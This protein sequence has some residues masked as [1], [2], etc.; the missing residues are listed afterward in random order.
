MGTSPLTVTVS[1]LSPEPEHPANA[2]ASSAAM[3][4]STGAD[5][6][7][8]CVVVMTASLSVVWLFSNLLPG[9][10]AVWAACGRQ[11]GGEMQGPG[12]I[13]NNGVDAGLR[14]DQSHATCKPHHE[15]TLREGFAGQS[16]GGE[17]RHAA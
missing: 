5:R 4:P 1:S 2:A 16:I 8:L 10:A 17:D 6:L 15:H 11:S 14:L 9:I 7:L 3:V 12:G 13:D